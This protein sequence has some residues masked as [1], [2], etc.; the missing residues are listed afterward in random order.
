M[1][2]SLCYASNDIKGTLLCFIYINI[3][4]S[5][6]VLF[7]IFLGP[8]LQHMEG[9][10]LGVESELQLPAYTTTTATLGLSYICDLLHSSWQR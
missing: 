6:I 10:R 1:I 9:P 5:D 4:L 3:C 7:F 8:Y 2:Q